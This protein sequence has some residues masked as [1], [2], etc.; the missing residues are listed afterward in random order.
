VSWGEL[1][2]DEL[3]SFLARG[4]RGLGVDVWWEL[5]WLKCDN[6]LTRGAYRVESRELR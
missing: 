1:G 6:W 3:L 5:V 4:G 2:V